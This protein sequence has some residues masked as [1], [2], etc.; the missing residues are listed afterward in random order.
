MAAW[1]NWAETVRHPE[2]AKVFEPK[3]LDELKANVKEAYQ[4]KSPVRDETDV[5][6]DIPF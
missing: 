1:N 5:D 4:P 3:S 6:D 2:R